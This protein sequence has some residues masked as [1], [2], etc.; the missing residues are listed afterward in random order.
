MVIARGCGKGKRELFNGYRVL[1]LQNKK[2]MEISCTTMYIQWIPL[3]CTLKNK[4]V[5]LPKRVKD[6]YLETCKIPKERN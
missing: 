2:H 4:T 3:Y 1:V 6:L 5:N